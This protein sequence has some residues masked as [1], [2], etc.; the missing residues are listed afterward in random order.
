MILFTKD[1][2]TNEIELLLEKYAKLE[3]K[4]VFMVIY[5]FKRISLEKY[6]LKLSSDD[7]FQAW[8]CKISTDP[9]SKNICQTLYNIGYCFKTIEAAYFNRF[10]YM[11]CLGVAQNK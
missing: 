7:G 8:E 3:L 6:K 5:S 1:K 10:H 4:E 2:Q 11:C 9:D